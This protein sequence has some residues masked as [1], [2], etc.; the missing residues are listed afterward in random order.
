MFSCGVHSYAQGRL[1]FAQ[2]QSGKTEKAADDN[3]NQIGLRA[4][5]SIN[6]PKS[7]AQL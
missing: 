5:A 1:R 3:K 7:S 4:S 2:R 6:K